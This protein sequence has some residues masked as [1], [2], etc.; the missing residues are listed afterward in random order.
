MA[1]LIPPLCKAAVDEL[2]SIPS[3]GRMGLLTK[4]NDIS[5][6]LMLYGVAT[7]R[8]INVAE[9]FCHPENRG[10]TGLNPYNVHRNLRIIKC[11]GADLKQLIGAAV[12]ELST[13]PNKK[14]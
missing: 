14:R 4:W 5:D 8:E 13:D 1:A 3:D 12:F 10:R 7:E 11:I 6:Y 2:L 9:L